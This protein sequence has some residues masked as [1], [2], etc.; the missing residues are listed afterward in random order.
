MEKGATEP[1]TDA[2]TVEAPVSGEGVVPESVDVVDTVE[3]GGASTPAGEP[4]EGVPLCSKRFCVR[5]KRI[6]NQK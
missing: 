2:T 3:K 4:W 6:L 5:K 1:M